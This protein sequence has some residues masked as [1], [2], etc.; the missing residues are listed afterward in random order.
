MKSWELIDYGHK[1]EEKVKAMKT[2]I[3]ENAQGTNSDR[4]ET[5]TQ[6]FGPEGRNKH[7]TRL[8]VGV[9]MGSWGGEDCDK[10]VDRGQG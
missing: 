1:I 7:S 3:K 4:K 5:R 8:V 10:A 9:E 6:R 2:E